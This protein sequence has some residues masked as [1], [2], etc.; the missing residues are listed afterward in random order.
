MTQHVCACV[1]VGV[2][3]KARKKKKKSVSVD[4]CLVARVNK[5]VILRSS[6]NLSEN[7]THLPSRKQM[8]AKQHDLEYKQKLQE[9]KDR[10]SKRRYLFEQVAVGESGT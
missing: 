9:M 4:R 6:D 3:K 10:V 8:A 1:W 5:W 7:S 2:K